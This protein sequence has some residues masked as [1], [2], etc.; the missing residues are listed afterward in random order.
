MYMEELGTDERVTYLIK[1]ILSV[2]QEAGGQLVKTEIRNRICEKDERIAEFEEKIYTS[3][4]TGNR[5]RKFD[6]SFNFAIKELGYTGFI[7]YEKNNPLI[8]M[9]EKGN[10][11]DLDNFD[12]VKEVREKAREYWYSFKQKKKEDASVNEDTE[13][14]ND[15]SLTDNHVLDDFKVSLQEAI[16]NMSA[17]KFELFSRALLKKIGVKFTRERY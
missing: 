2:L 11:L 17:I 10:N 6:F 7:N 12:T 16:S 4:K 15:R 14:D 13:D 8:T 9:S 5:D 1:P 3:K